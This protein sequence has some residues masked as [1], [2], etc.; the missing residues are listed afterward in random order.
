MRLNRLFNRGS[1]IR[2]SLSFPMIQRITQIHPGSVLFG[3]TIANTVF[4]RGLQS[5]QNIL[6][7]IYYISCTTYQIL[8]TNTAYIH[9]N[10]MYDMLHNIV[11]VL[12]TYNVYI[13]MNP[14]DT[15]CCMRRTARI[16]NHIPI[17][18]Y[19]ILYYNTIYYTI[20]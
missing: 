18:Y 12:C 4:N 8:R 2:G 14:P 7:A 15:T 6:H 10:T 16:S 1:L 3:Q 13:H 9:T 5:R 11:Y 19:T 20:L 17:L